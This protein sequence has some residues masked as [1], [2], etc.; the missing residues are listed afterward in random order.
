MKA[1]ILT[2]GKGTRMLP[3]TEIINK[4]LIPILNKPMIMYSIEFLKETLGIN[5]IL[6]ITSPKD[7]ETF[8]KFFGNGERCGVKLSF[9]IQ[10]KATGI[11]SAIAVGESFIPEGEKFVVLLGD[12]IFLS[13]T[14]EILKLPEDDNVVIFTH[15]VSNPKRFGVVVYDENKNP[16]DIEEKPENPKSNSIATG[17]YVYP[18]RAFDAIKSLAPSARGE[19][20][21]TDL[22]NY[23]LHKKECHAIAVNSFCDF[24]AD[25][26]TPESILEVSNYIF[27]SRSK[28]TI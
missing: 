1:I 22:N 27:N 21:V 5:E 6:I 11:A 10:E 3:A 24:W 2:A 8:E 23:F 4:N 7:L 26:G 12:N 25:A 15:E 16:I 20:E 28:H 14:N 9:T 18:Y 17:L 13:N 19:Y